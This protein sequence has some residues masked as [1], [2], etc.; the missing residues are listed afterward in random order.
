MN[1]DKN[2]VVIEYNPE[3]KEKS[4]SGKTFVL[5]TSSGFKWENGIGISYNIVKK[6]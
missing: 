4:K 6:V 1:F 2:Q 3:S 5:A